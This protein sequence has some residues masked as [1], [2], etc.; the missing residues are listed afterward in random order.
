MDMGSAPVVYSPNSRGGFCCCCCCCWMAAMRFWNWLNA[1]VRVSSS[2][3]TCWAEQ[4]GWKPEDFKQ[5]GKHR[6]D[7]LVKRGEAQVIV[8]ARSVKVVYSDL[9]EKTI[10]RLERMGPERRELQAAGPIIVIPPR[11]LSLRSSATGH[12]PWSTPR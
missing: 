6:P 3:G 1:I 9:L 10:N 5:D 8:A 12:G 2:R 7:F 11:S 4:A